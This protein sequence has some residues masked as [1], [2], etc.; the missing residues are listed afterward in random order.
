MKFQGKHTYQTGSRRN[1]RSDQ[2]RLET[3]N[4]LIVKKIYPLKL[5]P[6]VFKTIFLTPL[7]NR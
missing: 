5:D 4:K 3:S 1:R 7:R 6:D 2:S